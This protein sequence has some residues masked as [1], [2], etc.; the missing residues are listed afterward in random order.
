MRRHFKLDSTGN[1]FPS[2]YFCSLP[3]LSGWMT[4]K[5]SWAADIKQGRSYDEFGGHDQKKSDLDELEKLS[6]PSEMELF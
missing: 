5:T 4:E 2:V 3:A 1:F 6:G